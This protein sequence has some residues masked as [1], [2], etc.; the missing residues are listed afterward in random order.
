MF[1]TSSYLPQG[2]MDFSSNYEHSLAILDDGR[3]FVWGNNELGSLGMGHLLEQDRPIHSETP[4]LEEGEN[5]VDVDTGDGHSVGLTSDGRLFTWGRNTYGQLGTGDYVSSSIRIDITANLNLGVGES[6]AKVFSGRYNTF[7]LTSDSRVL[8]FGYNPDGQLGDLTLIDRNLPVDIT[9]NLG[10]D[11]GEVIIGVYPA[12]DHTLLYTSDG[13]I[14]AF[15][16]N[17]YGQL[18][19][20]TFDVN[21]TIVETTISNCITVGEDTIIDIEVGET[22]SGFIT[23][24]NE[25]CVWGEN[26]YGSLGEGGLLN[27]NLPYSITNQFSIDPSENI[28]QLAI[29][30]W[31]SMIYTD[32]G[33]TYS[34][35]Q[36]S[37]S[38]LGNGYNFDE[39]YPDEVTADFDLG[40]E[41]INNYF[42]G[43][44]TTFIFSTI[45]NLYGF[46]SN[47]DGELG[48]GSLSSSVDVIQINR[49]ISRLN[50]I[51][52]IYMNDEQYLLNS[53]VYID[54][55]F[56]YDIYDDLVSIVINGT[57]YSKAF[58]EEDVGKITIKIPNT[59][60]LNDPLDY[61]IETIN[62]SAG[63][64]APSGAADVFG[65]MVDDNESPSFET[66][67]DQSIPS[68]TSPIDWETYVLNLYDNSPGIISILVEDYIIYNVPGIY[69]V[70]ITAEDESSNSYNQ[71]FNVEVTDIIAPVI[72]YTG[73]TTLEVNTANY[74]I[75]TH[76]AANDNIDGNL[77]PQIITSGAVEYDQVGV[78]T[79]TFTVTD[80]S[81]N[82]GTLIVDINIVDTTP[83]TFDLIQDLEFEVGEYSSFDFESLVVNELDNSNGVLTYTVIESID[84]FALDTY[85]VTIIVEDES[86]NSTSDTFSVTISDSVPPEI[87]IYNEPIVGLNE[88]LND[89]SFIEAIDYF[90]GDVTYNITLDDSLV[91]YSIVGTYTITL[92]VYDSSGNNASTQVTLHVED[93]YAPYFDPIDT[94]I[95][96]LGETDIDWE[97]YIE[98]LT[99]DSGEIPTISVTFDDVDYSVVGTYSI[100]LEATDESM[101]SF[102]RTFNVTVEDNIDPDVT[103]IGEQ[104]LY[105]ELGDAYL[106]LGIE[107]VDNGLD[108]CIIEVLGT[109]DS[110]TL[111]TYV[112]T[113]NVTDSADNLVTLTRSVI[114]E[115][116]TAPVVILESSV[117]TIYSDSVY[118]DEGVI[119]IDLQAVTISVSGT[120][121][122]TVVGVYQ[123]IYTVTDASDNETIVKRVV[124]VVNPIPLVVFEIGEAITTI[125]VNS[126]FNEGSCD[127]YV[128]ITKYTCSVDL[129]NLNTATPGTYKVTYSTPTSSGVNYQYDV[130]VVVVSKEVIELVAFKE[131]EFEVVL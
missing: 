113:Y 94:V 93:Y 119:A 30:S 46:G 129:D 106:D 91:D 71:E 69:T 7:V 100:T 50:K 63:S 4:E 32:Y 3:L 72:T 24:T 9:S 42:L 40:S 74:D 83:P 37:Y 97:T 79:I 17:Q 55:Y 126:V 117:D 105:H 98:G 114:V 75:S 96:G 2:Y 45:D 8:S 66:I 84:F 14:L 130:V 78:Y 67:I 107:C 89:T 128:D 76:V 87:F 58:M 56:E 6:P 1:E 59:Y 64:I 112:I 36:G 54:L 120:V 39:E 103:L 21:H 38:K 122:E 57:T 53:D 127:V 60:A 51:K 33:R 23:N 118:T 52:F 27:R 81:L 28:I 49:D 102:E 47:V 80:S 65:V 19:M 77:S 88:N 104:T 99:D 108:E 41:D 70:S 124:T 115:D 85:Q 13:R 35:G 109:V 121:D 73:V 116:T 125:K 123:I 61:T 16:S 25:V 43:E 86:E 22:F 68:G 31:H 110:N 29:G 92:Y 131:N 44:H 101:N 18:G 5:Y 82:E 10:L 20:G 90:D 26:Q 12:T 34:W 111:G 48:I 95:I 15:G 11:P 62:F